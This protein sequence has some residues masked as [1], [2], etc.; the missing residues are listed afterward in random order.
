M[1]LNLHNTFAGAPRQKFILLL[2][3][4][5]FLPRLIFG[6]FVF[7]DPC[8]AA[9]KAILS[10]RFN[11]ARRYLDAEKKLNPANH[12]PAYLEN[13]MD[14]LTLFIN[15]EES[16]YNELGQNENERLRFLA[17]A[18]E[19]SPYYRFCMA[20]VRL[21]WAFVKLKF[22]DYLS[23]VS[24]I[25]KASRLLESNRD[26]YPDFLMNNCGLGIIHTMA[27][28]VPDQ[29]K[30]LANLIGMDGS[31]EQGISE[32]RTIVDYTGKDPVV[33]MFR[34]EILFYLSFIEVNLRKDRSEAL[35]LLKYSEG[36]PENDPDRNNPLTVYYR[37]SILMKTGNNDRA[38]ELL[39]T[40]PNSPGRFRISYLDFLMGTAK[41]NRLDPDAADYF[42]RFLGTFHGMN[43]IRAAYQ[44]MA[45][46][47]LISGDRKKYS[48]Y[49]A[50]I[51]H[52]GSS[53]VDED[54]QALNE[55]TK[56]EI[57]NM[58]LL[59]ARLL[60][61]GGYYDKA[62][63]ELLDRNLKETVASKKD[64]L[65]YVYR[66]GRIYHE[67]GNITKAKSCYE[68]TIRLGSDLPYYFAANSALQLGLIYE[69]EKNFP[70]AGKYFRLCLSMP[71][72]EYKNS[73]SQKAKTG[74]SRIERRKP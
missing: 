58:Y 14:F 18:D 42:Q 1:R 8:N 33:T 49:M 45:W 20:Q 13:Y 10:M 57:P 30:W 5:V 6:Q 22:G 48:E 29:Y 52:I 28:L 36:L 17:K 35:S 11:D 16:Q 4:F 46:S 3:A 59:K 61:D 47:A 71:N 62:L 69:N 40:N 38:I 26:R 63:H 9:Y 50:M 24:D 43:Y 25:R 27:G 34:Q 54:K 2:G 67:K 65:E 60:F 39:S 55:A 70:E 37:A 56:N 7:D 66:S 41:L 64:L 15:E 19:N 68:Q 72:E 31:V 12:I 51:P 74:L 53:T 32:L 21:Q 23:A 73:L 44:K